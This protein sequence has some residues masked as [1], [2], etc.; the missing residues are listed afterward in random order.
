MSGSVPTLP[1]LHGA[2]MPRIGLGTWP[3]G[4]REAGRAVAEALAMGYRLVDTAHAYGN[5]AGV[6]RGL[7]ASG[8]PREEV[9]VTTKL[10]AE[11]HGSTG[12]ARRA[13]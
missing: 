1:L 7:R 3:M 12:R 5:E 2:A 9:F 6:G 10:N 4:D 8:V 13:R 11:W